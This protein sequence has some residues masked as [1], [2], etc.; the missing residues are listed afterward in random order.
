MLNQSL[1]YGGRRRQ[2]ER[3]RRLLHD[4]IKVLL[5]GGKKVQGGVSASELVLFS[6]KKSLSGGVRPCMIP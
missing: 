1:N 2:R 6:E 4:E 3:E 5:K